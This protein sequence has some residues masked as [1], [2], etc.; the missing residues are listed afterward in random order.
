MPDIQPSREAVRDRIAMALRRVLDGSEEFYIEDAPDGSG[1][2]M[3]CVSK[4]PGGFYLEY[5]VFPEG[6]VQRMYRTTKD[7]PLETAVEL[8]V[9]YAT[10]GKEWLER[11]EWEDWTEEYHENAEPIGFFKMIG[12]GFVAVVLV[13]GFVNELFTDWTV[14]VG[15]IGFFAAIC[16]LVGI[17]YYCSKRF[18]HP[19]FKMR[20]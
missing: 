7:V 13:S 11:I 19:F 4:N 1:G 15:R 6:E 16:V 17:A 9:S 14:A 5:S 12:F 20:D 8:F 2:F 3:Q 18:K 10:G